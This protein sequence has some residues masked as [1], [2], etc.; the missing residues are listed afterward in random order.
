VTQTMQYDDLYR[1]VNIDYNYTNND[2]VW[3]SPFEDENNK[4]DKKIDPRRT[5][6]SPHTNFAQRVRTQRYN[7]DWL[8]NTQT[9]EDD[10][11]GFY[12][13]SLGT[14]TNNAAKPYQLTSASN[15]SLPAGN[16]DRRGSLTASY[17]DA[18]N[19]TSLA[20][21]RN[22][23]CLPVG[24]NC[25]Q[26]FVYDWDEVGRLAKARRWDLPNSGPVPIAQDPVPVTSPDVEL[27]YVYNGGDQRV[28]KTA[29]DPNGNER[30]TVYLFAS[31]ELRRAVWLPASEGVPADYERNKFTEV[32]YL[33]GMARLVYEDSD[34]P[35]VFAGKLHVFLEMG[36]HL[37]SSSMVLDKATGELVERTTY[38]AYGN[39]ESDYRPDRW[40][41]FREDYKFTGKEEDIE[42]GLQYFGFRYYAPAL[43]RWISADPLTIH[44]LGADLNAYAYVS[45]K[46][47]AATDPMG[48]EVENHTELATLPDQ[49]MYSDPGTQASGNPNATYVNWGE[50]TVYGYDRYLGGKGEVWQGFSDAAF[51]EGE[52]VV[53]LTQGNVGPAAKKVATTVLNNAAT[54]FLPPYGAYR[55]A[56]GIKD[57]AETYLNGNENTKQRMAGKGLWTAFSVTFNASLGQGISGEPIG[58][59]TSKWCKCICFE[60]GTQVVTIDGLKSIDEI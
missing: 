35:E 8:G 59:Y 44:G 60:A 13:R 25:W 43:N 16:P 14:I 34:V 37:G 9:S 24:A 23:P 53:A 38:E 42:V 40:K 5:R 10:V 20:V 22:G 18:G 27:K 12:D 1:L 45:G 52:P 36:N 49:Q 19:L 3:K 50:F 4:P 7:Y 55:A 6:P 41:S 29:V 58:G 57:A 2:D 33:S 48:L 21:K 39:T 31:L 28:I 32:G 54:L 30:H 46:V 15:E 56:K 11:G 47:L 17:D 26:R 51:K